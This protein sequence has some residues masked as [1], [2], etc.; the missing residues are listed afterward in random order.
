M[1]KYWSEHTAGTHYT[2]FVKPNLPPDVFHALSFG[3]VAMDLMFACDMRTL[4]RSLAYIC[5]C[6]CACVG[7]HARANSSENSKRYDTWLHVGSGLPF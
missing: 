3:F 2:L 1:F 4:A 7:V 6:V 5:M